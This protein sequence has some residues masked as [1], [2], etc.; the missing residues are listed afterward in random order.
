MPKALTG[1]QVTQLIDACGHTRD[2]FLLTLM[3]QT[4]MR[5]GQA[6]GLRHED[7]AVEDG[8][9]HIAP[10]EDNPNGARAKTRNAYTI[11][12]MQELMRL[13]TDYLIDDLSALETDVLPDF[14]FVNLWEGEI[15]HSMTYVAVMSLVKR[16]GKKTGIR[17]TPHML[18]HSRATIWIR[19]DQLA[20]P[21]V[22]RLLGHASIQ[23]TND[24][25]VQ[26]TPH[27][28][29]QVLMKEKENVSGNDTR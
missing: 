25:Y 28:L 17:F 27:D 1:E 18:R 11:P 10:R 29:K 19:D 16:L 3:Y 5:V 9:I 2:K 4:G 8:E 14:V 22:S 12:A 26:L 13:Y 23:T 6:L 21:I 15:G 7:I 20:L 24:T